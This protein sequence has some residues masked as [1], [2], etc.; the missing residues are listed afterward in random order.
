MVSGSVYLLG[1]AAG[2]MVVVGDAGAPGPGAFA[3][4]IGIGNGT[5]SGSTSI[6]RL[7]LIPAAVRL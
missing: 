6:L 2:D 7:N 5:A 4:V 1:T 3:T